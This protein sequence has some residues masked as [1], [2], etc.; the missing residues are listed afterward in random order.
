MITVSGLT[1]QY[2]SSSN[3]L[4]FPDFSVEAGKSCLLLGESGSGKTTLLHLMGGLLKIQSGK[5]TIK[6]TSLSDLP[7]SAADKF[8]GRHIG[9]IFQKNHLLSSLTVKQNLIIAPFLS[10]LKQDESRIEE[11]L[12]QL[13]L[14]DKK[15]SRIHQL[16]QGQA[17]RVAIARAVIN[18]PAIIFADEPTSALDD[19]NCERVI[20][21][22]LNIAQQY[23]CTLIIATHDQRLKSIVSTHVL[24][25]R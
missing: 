11:V 8:R 22:L 9:F 20:S 10:N 24:L 14:W 7:E 25:N 3:T 15:Q 23:Q 6:N 16:S 2:T 21:L 18:K 13:G 17:Q 12:A 4:S 5:I 19:H 1:Y